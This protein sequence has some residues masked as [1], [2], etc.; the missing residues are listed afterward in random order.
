MPGEAGSSSSA[1]DLPACARVRT[2]PDGRRF[3]GKRSPCFRTGL[4]NDRHQQRPIQR[5]CDAT[6][7]NACLCKKSAARVELPVPAGV[8]T[9]FFA[10]SCR[11]F[12]RKNSLATHPV[13]TTHA[14]TCRSLSSLLRSVGHNDSVFLT[15]QWI[16]YGPAATGHLPSSRVKTAQS[17]RTRCVLQVPGPL[18]FCR[19]SYYGSLSPR[20]LA[21]TVLANCMSLAKAKR[22]E[23]MCWCW[24][25]FAS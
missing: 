20:S 4:W 19:Q 6:V 14:A 2:I 3:L 11:S 17:R 8:R 13:M 23:Q 16:V 7:W 10:D 22:S 9:L 25:R 21:D 5:R 15:L 12:L 1:Q 24:P 18:L